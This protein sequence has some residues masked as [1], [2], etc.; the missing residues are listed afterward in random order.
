MT[1]PTGGVVSAPL[2]QTPLKLL[3]S[4][5]NQN[6]NHP[7]PCG[8][9]HFARTLSVARNR[10]LRRIGPAWQTTAAPDCVHFIVPTNIVGPPA[11]VMFQVPFAVIGDG[12]S[13]LLPTN[14]P[15]GERP[16]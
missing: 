5:L 14:E 8:P 6:E 12:G 15:L 2:P 3:L 4:P 7:E 11:P 16:L 10:P 13:T 9:V 1:R